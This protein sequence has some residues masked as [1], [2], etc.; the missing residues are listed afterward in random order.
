MQQPRLVTTRCLTVVCLS[1]LSVCLFKVIPR[2]AEGN[3]MVKRAV[4]TKPALLGQKLTHQ[5]TITDRYL[6]I[7]CDVGTS[8]VAT[9]LV[10]MLQQYAKYVAAGSCPVGCNTAHTH[11]TAVVSVGFVLLLFFFFCC[12]GLVASLQVPG[13]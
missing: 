12:C 9:A 1:V 4:G 2:I 11:T 10:G 8:R 5:W 6:D 7:S 3:W 13:H